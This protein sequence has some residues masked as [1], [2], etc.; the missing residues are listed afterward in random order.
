MTRH[1]AMKGAAG[2]GMF[3]PD[4]VRA[5]VTKAAGNFPHLNRSPAMPAQTLVRKK[6]KSDQCAVYDADGN[7]VGTCDPDSITMVAAPKAPG[8]PAAPPTDL[9]PAPAASVGTPA[10]AVPAAKAMSAGVRGQQQ[11][12]GPT[13]R[14]G[15]P[16]VPAEGEGD[17]LQKAIAKASAHAAQLQKQFGPNSG[18]SAVEQAAATAQLN[19]L[20]FAAISATLKRGTRVR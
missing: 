7:L 5:L 17:E 9:T 15:V 3:T 16:V 1:I 13:P 10:D 11:L 8:G 4:E 18:A 2:T 6:A 19:D 12:G 20:A 14:G